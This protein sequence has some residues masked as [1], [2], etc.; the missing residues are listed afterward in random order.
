LKGIL[1]M[2]FV[3]ALEELSMKMVL[4]SKVNLKI[5]KEMEK[6]N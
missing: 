6:E 1:K 4:F 2:A 3:K 5:I